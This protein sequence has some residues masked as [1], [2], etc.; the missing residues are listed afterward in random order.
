MASVLSVC[1]PS[2]TLLQSG[3]FNSSKSLLM[4]LSIPLVAFLSPSSGGEDDSNLLVS[5]VP[6]LCLCHE[7]HRVAMIERSQQPKKPGAFLHWREVFEVVRVGSCRRTDGQ[8]LP[9]RTISPMQYGTILETLHPIHTLKQTN[10][11]VI[12]GCVRQC[13]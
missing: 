2:H 11:H 1:D 3:H 5:M 6:S 10:N 4:D 7:D 8:F 13:R 12:G 9:L